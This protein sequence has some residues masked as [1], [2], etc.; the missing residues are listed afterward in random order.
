MVVGVH[1]SLPFWPLCATP[2]LLWLEK[3]FKAQLSPPLPQAVLLAPPVVVDTSFMPMSTISSTVTVLSVCCWPRWLPLRLSNPGGRSLVHTGSECVSGCLGLPDQALCWALGGQG[4]RCTEF[5]PLVGGR[6]AR[7]GGTAVQ[8][9]HLSV[10]V[11]SAWGRGQQGLRG[12]AVLGQTL[13]SECCLLQT[14]G[15]ER[16]QKLS[17]Q[18]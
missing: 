3:C 4:P 6:L 9:A 13:E 16:Q 11:I 17:R 5:L 8:R 18:T 10:K 1:W 14:V 12:V 7:G 2:P 15:E